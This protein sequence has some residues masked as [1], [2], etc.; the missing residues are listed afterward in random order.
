M[1]PQS[2]TPPSIND[3]SEG[4]SPNSLPSLITKVIIFVAHPVP[5][6]CTLAGVNADG[7]SARVTEDINL[8]L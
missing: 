6:L 4:V 1:N 2:A 3:H 5:T 7:C 8:A